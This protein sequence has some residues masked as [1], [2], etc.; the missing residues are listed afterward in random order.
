MNLDVNNLAQIVG[1][2]MA[3]KIQANPIKVLVV[4][5]ALFFILLIL[6][7]ALFL[8]IRHGF[9]NRKIDKAK[10]EAAGE[11]T[12]AQEE[13]I[14]AGEIEIDRKAEDLNRERSL[15]PNR[16][17]SAATLEEAT[18]RRKAAEE[19]YEKTRS[20]RRDPDP[21]DLTLHRRNCSDLVE[22]YPDKTFAGC[23]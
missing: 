22:L 17:E 14:N 6:A 23:R 18:R 7:P 20:T 4:V 21:D 19:V 16:K 2:R 5:V 13:R 15:E 1:E 3:T 8:G 9:S 10:T 11:K 12:A